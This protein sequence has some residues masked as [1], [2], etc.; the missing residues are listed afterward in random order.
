VQYNQL[1]HNYF[2]GTLGLLQSRLSYQARVDG[3]RWVQWPV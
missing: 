3:E 1:L 2:S